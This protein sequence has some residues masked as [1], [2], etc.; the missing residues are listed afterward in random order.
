MTESS[1]INNTL[2]PMRNV[3]SFMTMM[4]RLRGR[5][6]GMPGMGVFY[7]PAGFGKSMAAMYCATRSEA[8]L[9]EC[10]STWTPTALC[11]AILDEL[12]VKPQK[13]VW[14]MAKQIQQTLSSRNIPLI[15]D[16]VDHIV[17]KK[18]IELL[19]DIYQKSQVPVVLIGEEALPWEL[20]KWERL[21]SRLL[22]RV[23][24]EPVDD[25]DYN[26]LLAIRCPDF[27]L[28]DELS[29][30]VK[31]KSHGSARL[32]VSNLD[33]IRHEALV[34]GVS[35]IVRREDIPN[36]EFHTGTPPEMRRFT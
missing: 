8:C 16:E 29:E 36:F 27:E 10:E 35:G 6:D 21:N 15:I 25:V 5:N 12:A 20:R 4:E 2:A 19:R 31:Q 28:A 13:T 17:S 23:A 26:A 14:R 11:E 22:A 33:G 24:A 1:Q 18:Y 32:I 30:E 7:G 34:M 9:V 3:M